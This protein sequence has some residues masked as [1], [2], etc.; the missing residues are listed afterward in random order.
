MLKPKNLSDIHN[1][2]TDWGK[3]AQTA[4]EGL[5]KPPLMLPNTRPLSYSMTDEDGLF[6]DALISSLSRLYPYHMDLIVKHY[7]NH[8]SLR[9]IARLQDLPY[10]DISREITRAKSLVLKI[11][12]EL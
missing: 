11:L 9:Y 1:L 8:K 4:P 5:Y 12:S 3:W 7:V 6:L 2:L 10:A